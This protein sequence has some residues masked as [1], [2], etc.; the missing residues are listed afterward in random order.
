MLAGA[1][2]AG[3][4]L[5]KQSLLDVFVFAV[6]LLLVSRRRGRRIGRG[7]GALATVAVAVW[8]ASTRGTDPGDL[9]DAVV[10]FRQQAASVIAT[11]AT[12]STPRRLAAMLLALLA[13]GAPVLAVV[14]ARRCPTGRARPDPWPEP[15][16]ALAGA[17]HPRLGADRGAAAAA[18]TGCTT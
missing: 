12:G 18:A 16:P 6:V 17:R 2:G 15:R 11:S 4:A 7:V 14:L 13:S 8:L 5:V 1:A 3:G 9:W 10:V